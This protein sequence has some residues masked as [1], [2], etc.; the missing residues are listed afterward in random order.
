MNY[1]L[2]ISGQHA[3]AGKP[4]ILEPGMKTDAETLPKRE[5]VRGFVAEGVNASSHQDGAHNV[6]MFERVMVAIANGLAHIT[7]D[8]REVEA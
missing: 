8:G 5:Y 2:W 1:R 4:W 3:A 6:V 7:P